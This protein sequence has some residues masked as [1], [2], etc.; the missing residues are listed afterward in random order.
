MRVTRNRLIVAA[1]AAFA[2]LWFFVIEPAR[3]DDSVNGVVAPRP[4][5]P[6][7][8]IRAFHATIGL[9]D[10]HADQLLWARDL[11]A[12]ATR[13]HVSLDRLEQGGFA[14]QVFSSV[15][16]SPAGL[17][18]ERNSARAFDML[19]I[20][21]VAQ[22]QP[23]RTWFSPLARSL[24]QASRLQR[25]AAQSAGR[26]QLVTSVDDLQRLADARAAG[27]RTVGGLLA[28][29]GLHNLQGRLG[30]L[31]RLHAAGY[32]MAGLAHFIDN[33]VAGSAHGETRHGLTPFGFRVVRRM[34]ER[35]MIVDLAHVS[36]RA[37]DD[38]LAMAQRPVVVSHTGVKGTCDNNRNLSDDQVRR[39]AANG[40]LIGIGVWDTAVCGTSPDAIVR[41]MRHVARLV[42]VGHVALGSD[43]DGSIVANIR[44]DDMAAL[45]ARMLDAGF[46]RAD[47]RAI[48]GGNATAFLLRGLTP[49]ALAI[50]L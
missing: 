4:A 24:H 30:N 18:I 39:I 34:E 44:P 50:P 11:N 43:W 23:P 8:D 5:R 47:C 26:L 9:V 36:P 16:Q 12:P 7:A 6:G 1:L 3:F 19:N 14:L 10:L 48:L 33:E 31:D 38:V 32:R 15:S 40:G 49:Q 41:A 28:L 2:A 27:A 13:G 46:S 17:N 21:S 42:G 37:I 22:R 45:T 25:F 35:G 20:L 29:E